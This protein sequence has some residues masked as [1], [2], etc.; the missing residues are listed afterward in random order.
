M[1]TVTA[2][3]LARSLCRILD[4]AES[5]GEEVAQSMSRKTAVIAAP[6]PTIPPEPFAPSKIAPEGPDLSA[7]MLQ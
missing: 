1:R 4:H 3:V 2:T 5:R 7:Q 6:V